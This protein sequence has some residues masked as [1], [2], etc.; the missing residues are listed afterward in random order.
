[1]ATYR[2]GPTTIAAH[3]KLGGIVLRPKRVNGVV[4]QMPAKRVN[5]PSFD[6][7]QI[8]FNGR[9][10]RAWRELSS[11]NRAY[12]ETMVNEYQRSVGFTEVL[13]MSAYALYTRTA[14]SLLA[15]GGP[16]PPTFPVFQI[17]GRRQPVVMFQPRTNDGEWGLRWAPS[18]SG[19]WTTLGNWVRIRA[20]AVSPPSRKRPGRT[21]RTI[22]HVDVLDMPLGT[23]QSAYPLSGFD[24]GMDRGWVRFSWVGWDRFG[25]FSTERSVIWPVLPQDDPWFLAIGPGVQGSPNGFITYDPPELRVQWTNANGAFDLSTTL[26]VGSMLTAGDVATWLRG[27]TGMRLVDPAAT[28]LT[29]PALDLHPIPGATT[30]IRDAPAVFDFAT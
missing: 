20:S 6:Q 2:I 30:N 24:F 23:F 28:S 19:E 10:N 8:G 22:E 5:K 9:A 18:H 11:E 25:W 14:V 1:M 16:F 17:Q 15:A 4:S 29:A 12:W 13:N 26:G 21:L 7:R 27:F 3:G